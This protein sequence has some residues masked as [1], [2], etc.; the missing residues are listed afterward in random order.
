[1]D[2]DT[3]TGREWAGLAVLALPTLLV[4]IDIFVLLLAL[5]RLT[6]DLHASGTQRLW[7]SDI[8]GFLLVGFL[9]TMGTLG[10]RTGRRRV[11]LTGAAAFGAA[12][13]LAAYSTSPAMLI[14]A[15]ALLGIAGATLSPSTL[16]LIGTMFR[17]PRQ[18][19]AA[20][21]VWMACFMSG[22]AIGPM[23]GGLMLEHF[24]WGSVFL[25]AVPAMALLLILGPVVL[26]E[27]RD[28]AARRLDLGSVLLS[29]AAILPVAYALTE[30][31][32]TGLR[33]LPAAAG[34]AGL[35]LG[36]V[37]V[38]RQ[39]KLTEPLL[40]LRLLT[41]RT[42]AAAMSGMTLS[43][44]LTG[45]T[46]LFGT[47]YFEVAKGLS[48]VRAGLCMVPA[49]V[50]MT[51][52]ALGAPPLAR[53]A[54]PA[55]VIAAGLAVATGGLLLIGQVN[56][57]VPVVAGWALVALGS[58]PMVVLSVDLVIGAAPPA[59]AGAAAAVNETGSQLGFA[60]GIAALGGLSMRVAATT[61]AVLLAVVAVIT[62][63][64]LR[65]AGRGVEPAQTAPPEHPAE[66]G[67]PAALR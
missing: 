39:R 25:L 56:G 2:N 5:P 19:A 12:S 24:W 45:A 20:I 4:S 44:M 63:F 62:I 40:D 33:P 32:R 53:R 15:R 11:L 50:T 58:G 64:L 23:A 52:S 34:V 55:Y 28:P 13:V 49:A 42:F 22:A 66:A 36:A 48:P 6:Q 29:L 1:M 37:F 59:R 26:P 51:A 65:H 21:G 57:L 54:R 27:Y 8:Y 60:L 43:T 35:A 41:N 30:T 67:A 16:A 9:V 14:A 38:R 47:Q 61:S 17:Q 31:A 10:D 18:R 7:I 46:M 3:A